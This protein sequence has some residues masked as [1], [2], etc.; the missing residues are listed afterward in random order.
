MRD[1][2]SLKEACKILSEMDNISV[3]GVNCI[4]PLITSDIIMKLKDYS[5]KKILV[6][7]NSG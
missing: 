7:P 1:N 2:S 4:D 6:Y 5:S 3:I